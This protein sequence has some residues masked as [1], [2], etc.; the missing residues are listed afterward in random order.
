MVPRPC[1]HS[2]IGPRPNIIGLRCRPMYWATI[3]G[4]QWSLLGNPGNY[5]HAGIIHL[6]SSLGTMIRAPRHGCWNGRLGL[7]SLGN[8]MAKL[9]SS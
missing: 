3:A 8:L 4:K 2:T 9:G 6:C 5:L 1:S 7:L